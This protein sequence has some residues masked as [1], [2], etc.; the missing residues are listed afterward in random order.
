MP[1]VNKALEKIQADVDL[2]TKRDAHPAHELLEE[3]EEDRA[4]AE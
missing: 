1:I 2:E 4:E 3:R